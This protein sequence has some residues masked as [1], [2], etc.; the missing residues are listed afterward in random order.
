MW[1]RAKLR[2]PLFGTLLRKM[3]IARMSRTLGTLLGNGVPILHALAI[4]KDT[5]G[6]EVM[7][8][9]LQEV[10]TSV[11]EGDTI[12]APLVRASAFP[13]LFIHMV[14]VGEETGQVDAMLEHVADAY[15]EEVDDTVEALSSLIEPILLVSLGAIV[16]FIVIALFMPLIEGA[17]QFGM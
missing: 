14:R 5:A 17:I 9:A 10:R 15:D 4:A 12:A 11:R 1:D 6:N 7:R 16:G 3:A 2:A 8:Q 13:A